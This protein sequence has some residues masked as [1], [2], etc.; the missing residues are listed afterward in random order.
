MCMGC[1][2]GEKKI[3]VMAGNLEEY[4]AYM[5][6]IPEENRGKYIYYDFPDRIMGIIAESVI[7]TG[8][9]YKRKD[10]AE[11]RIEALSRIK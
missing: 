7:E 4:R 8:T 2:G 1:M 11:M 10:I 5:M 3:I 9:C 6:L